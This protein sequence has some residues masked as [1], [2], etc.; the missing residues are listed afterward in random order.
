M[1]EFIKRDAL[2]DFYCKSCPVGDGDKCIGEGCKVYEARKLVANIPSVIEVEPVRYGQWENPT[3]SKPR[4]FERNGHTFI[5]RQCTEC[6]LLLSWIK[7]L[8]IWNAVLKLS[9]YI[10]KQGIKQKGKRSLNCKGG[11]D[12]G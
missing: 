9:G 7:S 12:N 5:Q 2:K 1:A 11:A 10:M 8:M 4:M 3:E 6:R